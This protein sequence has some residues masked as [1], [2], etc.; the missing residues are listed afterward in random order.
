MIIYKTIVHVQLYYTQPLYD[1]H[2]HSIY[3]P[4]LCVLCVGN[5]KIICRYA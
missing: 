4:N 3:R 5:I 2:T 1:A